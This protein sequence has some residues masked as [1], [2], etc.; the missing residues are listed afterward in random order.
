MSKEE[1]VALQAWLPPRQ[2]DVLRAVCELKAQQQSATSR[3]ICAELLRQQGTASRE[4]GVFLQDLITITR[5]GLVYR[6]GISYRPT[7]EGTV[8][9]QHILK[10]TSPEFAEYRT[11]VSTGEQVAV[12]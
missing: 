8:V 10:S 2:F 3:D 5:K 9:A 11:W 7:H 12:A 1:N 6:S 4:W